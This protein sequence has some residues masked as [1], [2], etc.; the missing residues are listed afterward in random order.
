MVTSRYRQL[1]ADEREQ[2][3]GAIPQT[4]DSRSGC[5]DLFAGFV[6]FVLGGS[7]AGMMLAAILCYF[8]AW[9]RIPDSTCRV[10]LIVG[11]TA[12]LI[13]PTLWCNLSEGH[14]VRKAKR[15]YLPD[16]RGGVA[17]VTRYEVQ[18]AVGIEDTDY[19]ET[20]TGYFLDSG[21]GLIVYLDGFLDDDEMA[22]PTQVVEVGWAPRSRWRLGLSCSGEPVP[23]TRRQPLE[24]DEYK[25]ADGEVLLG[26][27]AFLS[28][29]LRML[30]RAR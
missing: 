18:A 10:L 5:W 29:V 12:G 25:P 17:E 4:E 30:K 26:S 9:F 15:R 22:F 8:L 28:A 24:Y 13:V 7:L 1:T 27:L 16:L 6:F 2:L 23:L 21:E 3:E 14:R 20:I 19:P 11:A